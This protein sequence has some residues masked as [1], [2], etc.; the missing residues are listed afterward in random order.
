MPAGKLGEGMDTG[1]DTIAVTLNLFEIF[2][3][4]F[5]KGRSISAA[6]LVIPEVPDAFFQQFLTHRNAFF[7][8]AHILP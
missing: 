6:W 3:T 1:L 7:T 5:F 8:F 4:A 2:E